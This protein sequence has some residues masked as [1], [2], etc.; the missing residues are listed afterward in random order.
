MSESKTVVIT[1]ATDG[2]GLETAKLFAID[3]Y[4]IIIHGR[5]AHKL[6][7]VKEELIALNKQVIVDTY[8][9]DLSDMQ[10]VKTLAQQLISDQA[11]IDI[12]INN[13]GVFKTENPKT[14]SGLDIRFVVNSL[15]PYYLTKLLMA[16]FNED[17]RVINLSSA[18]QEP[19]DKQAFFGH[20]FVPDMQAYAQSKRAI[21]LWTKALALQ[22]TS[23]LMLSVN[24]GS[25]LA[26]KMVKEGFGVAGSD[27]SIGANILYK[28]A[29]DKQMLAFHGQYFD[30]DA[31]HF[32][33]DIEAQ[34]EITQ[35]N[36][37]VEILEE[38]LDDMQLV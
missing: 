19:I 17:S 26:S 30:N 20:I 5:N 7:A 35:A 36:E 6:L 34:D 32:S 16:R 38:M 2:I 23:P 1:G 3:G 4:H 13:A 24:P 31:G 33:Q 22:N 21:R 9:A 25:L 37:L 27:L 18:A 12:L 29:T 28:L 15:A 8:L 10:A 11:N 14:N